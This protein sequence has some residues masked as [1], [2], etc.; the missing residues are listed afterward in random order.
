MP[1]PASLTKIR[2]A[3]AAILL[4]GLIRRRFQHHALRFFHYERIAGESDLSG[5]LRK[6]E[7][8]TWRGRTLHFVLCRVGND[9]QPDF[10]GSQSANCDSL[11]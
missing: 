7:K 4:F 10:A 6:V 3:A 11:N 2:L 9:Y 1:K 8:R 5:I